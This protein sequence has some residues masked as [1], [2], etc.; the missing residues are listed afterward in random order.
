M[1]V[2]V[3]LLG[4]G[5]VG[6]GVVN[7]TQKRAGIIADMTGYRPVVKR[8]LVRDLAKRRDVD[9]NSEVF[10]RDADVVLADPEIQVIV[11]TMGGIEPAR[12]YILA[13]LRRGK[14]V[15]TANKDLIALHGVE[16]LET[17][18]DAGV[19]ILFEASVGGA[20]PLIGPLQ[21]N[22]TANEVTDLKGIINGTTNYILT[23]M[24]ETG[25]DFA[26]ALAEAQ[27]LGYAEANPASDVDGLDAARKLVILA[28]IAFHAHVRL[29]E[30]RVEGIRT[31]TA[32]DVAYAKELGTVVKLV[33]SGSDRGGKLSLSVRPTLIPQGHPLAHV[34]GSY[35]ALFVRGDAAGDLMFFGRG[36]GSLPT[37][38]AVMGDVISLLRNMRL[39]VTSSR[40][41]RLVLDKQVQMDDSEPLRHYL[42]MS[43]SDQ[44]GVFAEIARLFAVA[45]ISMETV[46][47]K[48]VTA[49][50]AEIVVVTHEIP[51]EVM[52]ET[53]DR[54]RT[55]S[56]V[57][58]VHCVMPVEALA[59]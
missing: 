8:V 11:E 9:L 29:D 17:A 55:S 26:Q 15:V 19:D 59:E 42:R 41:H 40:N 43:V 27:E 30:V 46:L 32:Q 49:G 37:A 56:H 23:Q 36:A 45:G 33:A 5:T 54:L 18:R 21:D 16:I 28:S 20:I 14:H 35:N 4:C 50:T 38:S 7:L 52:N 48:R 12:T 3:G 2:Y 24:T 25:M 6:Q 22:L 53:I 10:T 13:A 39:G 1:N 44:P 57:Q 31:V 34:S 47:Q 51:V 58:Q